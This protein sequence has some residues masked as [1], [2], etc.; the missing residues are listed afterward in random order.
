MMAWTDRHCRYLHRL[1]A[2]RAL[3]FTEMVTAGALL[4]GPRERLLRFDP[5]EHPVALQLGGS[6]PQELAGAA[7][8]AADAGFDEI[9]LN[10]GCP[11]PRVREGR[12]GACLMR[13]PLLVADCIAALCSAVDL[14]VTVK[15]RLG[16]DND[17]N[18]ELLGAFVETVA[19]AGCS[20]FYV[21]ARKALLN[22][23]SPAQNRSIP[24]LQYPRAYRL[25]QDFPC[26]EFVI[27]GGIRDSTSVHQHLHRMDGV[28]IGRAAYQDP[29]GLA[30]VHASVYGNA[31]PGPRELMADYQSY[32]NRELANGTRLNDMTRHTLGLFAGIPGARRY[33]QLLSDA[34]R[35]R[36]NDLALVSEALS[37]L[38]LEAA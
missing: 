11:S 7:K 15:C 18:D 8:L 23:L 34:T 1:A 16:V 3:L 20:T 19:A 22:G 35:L 10:V 25:K 37:A 26:L 30:A 38:R 21:H 31:A 33:R 2:P 29:S 9:N 12:F 5:S 14:P 17:D 4:H 28:M 13:E 32:M 27:N 6:D 24:P 36:A